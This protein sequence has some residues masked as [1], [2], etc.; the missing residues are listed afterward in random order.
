MSKEQSPEVKSLEVVREHC[1]DM[2]VSLIS[3]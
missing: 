3:A 2:Y 1:E